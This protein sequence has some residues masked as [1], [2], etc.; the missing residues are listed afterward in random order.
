MDNDCIVEYYNSQTLRKINDLTVGNLRIEKAWELLINNVT[1]PPKSILELGCGIGAFSWR[2]K[3]N[4]ADALVLGMDISPE[5]IYVAKQLFSC[6]DL[7]YI[8]H[9]PNEYQN[10]SYDLVVLIDVFEHIPVDDRQHLYMML[11]ECLTEFGIIVLT[12][13]TPQYLQW[14]RIHKPSEIQPIDED[15]TVN[16]LVEF[17]TAT[18]TYI[19]F[20]K[21]TSVWHSNDYCHAILRRRKAFG[22]KAR[23]NNKPNIFNKIRKKIYAPS[24]FRNKEL[25]KIAK[26]ASKVFSTNIRLD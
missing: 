14:L 23:S 25:I 22:K 21:E 17:S 7:T 15:I 3:Q 9:S 13:P 19:D 1:S 5:S 18:N 2:M 11:N 8:L 20:F 26:N 12:F 4:W 24:K 16:T 6:K 10:Q